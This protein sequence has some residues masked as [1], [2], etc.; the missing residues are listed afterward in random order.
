MKFVRNLF[1]VALCLSI[2]IGVFTPVSQ[3]KAADPAVVE[4][5][6]FTPLRVGTASQVY[7]YFKNTAKK[8]SKLYTKIVEKDFPKGNEKNWFVQFCYSNICYLEDG[9][10]PK[11]IRSGEKEEMHVTLWPYEG[12]K[13]GEKIKIVLEVNPIVDSKNKTVITFYAICVAPKEIKLTIGKKI[14]TVNSKSVTLDVAPYVVSGRTLVPLRFIGENLGAE[15]A[16][17]PKTQKITFTLSQKTVI[18]WVG[19]TEVQV[20]IGPSYTKMITIDA[21]PVI[22][23]GRTFVPVRA[24]S[25]L[26]G[27]EVLYDAPTRVITIHFPPLPTE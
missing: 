18:F 25:E 22:S 2:F 23:S 17:E 7:F 12:A 1:V 8:Q 14:A 5:T 16:W 26:L 3:I 13:V 4:D 21:A 6:Y 10:S 11:T 15:I 9:E 19:K 27:G 24:V 20:K